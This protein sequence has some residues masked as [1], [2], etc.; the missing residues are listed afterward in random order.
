MNSATGIETAAVAWFA[1]LWSSVFGNHLEWSGFI[2]SDNFA[3]L[4][5]CCQYMYMMNYRCTLYLCVQSIMMRISCF[6]KCERRL[7]VVSDCY[8]VNQF[9]NYLKLKRTLRLQT[10][11]RSW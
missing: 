2:I 6:E 9:S 5:G 8:F 11:H 1:T 7:S 3:I 10:A 4:N